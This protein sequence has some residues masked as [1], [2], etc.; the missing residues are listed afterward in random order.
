MCDY[1]CRFVFVEQPL[2]C[3]LVFF[4]HATVPSTHR[5]SLL[6]F[7]FAMVSNH[8]GSRRPHDKQHHNT[9]T[10]TTTGVHPKSALFLRHLYEWTLASS[11]VQEL[12][13]DA[14]RRLRSW[15]R[16]E[17]MTVAMALAESTHHSSRGQKN[18]RAGVWEREMNYTATIRDPPT[19]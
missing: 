6:F 14:E 15:L 5:S 19:P 4:F 13:S 11:P 10:A 18:A 16:H 12:H 17:R 9:T 2:T 3:D 1:R 8:K 7:L